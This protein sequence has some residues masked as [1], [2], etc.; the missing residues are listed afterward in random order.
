LQEDIENMSETITHVDD[1]AIGI[2]IAGTYRHGTS[3]TALKFV[4]V[5]FVLSLAN[6][7]SRTTD[8]RFVNESDPQHYIEL[9]PDGVFLV[10]SHGQ[11]ASGTYRIN[12]NE[13]TYE[14]SRETSHFEWYPTTIS[15][16]VIIAGNLVFR[17][18]QPASVKDNSD[19]RTFGESVTNYAILVAIIGAIASIVTALISKAGKKT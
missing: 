2:D 12:G 13:L 5:L 17:R 15:G 7:S 4:V 14:V 10:F 16:D 9:K 1:A 19:K 11:I 6:C 18:T 3:A 8:G